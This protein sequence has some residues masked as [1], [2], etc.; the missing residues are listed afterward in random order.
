MGD[1]LDVADG[2]A[3]IGDTSRDRVGI[4]DRQQRPRVSGRQM[5]FGE[6]APRELGKFQKPQRVRDVATALAD[7]ASEIALRISELGAELLIAHRLFE[8]IEIGA[9]DVLDHR[10]LERCSLIR[11]DQ[12]D[13]HVVHVGALRRA[14]AAFSRNDFVSVG[15]A[16]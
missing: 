3:L 8:R 11:F 14:P 16:R 13:G 15:D 1:T 7:D 10:D 12:D 5:S 2:E 9:L 4:P 6:H